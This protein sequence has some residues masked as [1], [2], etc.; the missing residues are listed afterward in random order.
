MNGPASGPFGGPWG[1]ADPGRPAAAC[2]GDD[3]AGVAATHR[4]PRGGRVEDL[5]RSRTWGWTVPRAGSLHRAG[6]R[7]GVTSPREEARD[8][9]GCLCPD[10]V[11][12]I[13][14][15]APKPGNAIDAR[16]AVELRQVAE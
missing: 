12:R 11:G 14:P 4:G 15:A 16:R 3:R 1:G 7:A 6:D 13:T 9:C 2:S 8:G 10:G 5:E